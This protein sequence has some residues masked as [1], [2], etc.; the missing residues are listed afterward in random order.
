MSDAFV[1]LLLIVTKC[2]VQIEKKT[3]S[4]SKGTFMLLSLYGFHFRLL[5]SCDCH[6]NNA[7]NS[8]H[9]DQNFDFV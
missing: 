7:A 2:T 5:L 4:Y 8:I 6:D 3:A 9:R 1:G